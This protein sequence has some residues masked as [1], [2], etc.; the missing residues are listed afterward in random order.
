M[1]SSPL[2]H[3]SAPLLLF[4]LGLLLY[5]GYRHMRLL[6]AELAARMPD[7]LSRLGYRVRGDALPAVVYPTGAARGTL[8][9]D[10]HGVPVV[11]ETGAVVNPGG[12]PLLRVSWSAPRP[13][14]RSPAGWQ[15]AT[16]VP[17]QPVVWLRERRRIGDTE[18]DRR[19]HFRGDPEALKATLAADPVLRPLLLGLDWVD[20]QVS[21]GRVTFVDSQGRN[22]TRM[23]GGSVGVRFA[24]AEE[25]LGVHAAM[26]EQLAELLARVVRASP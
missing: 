13:P 19:F 9:R 26:H 23:L 18:L 2:A 24:S 16:R 6:R 15:L 20:L 11:F 22:A 12:P 5:G 10:F 1:S 4:T 21:G 8:D 17:L 7:F 14:H 3:V 25:Q